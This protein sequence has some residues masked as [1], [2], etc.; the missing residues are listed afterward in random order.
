MDLDYPLSIFLL[1]LLFPGD[2]EQEVWSESGVGSCLEIGWFCT[3]SICSRGRRC[4]HAPLRLGC[5]PYVEKH[6]QPHMAL[7]SLEALSTSGAAAVG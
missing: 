2:A 5:G 7:N 1:L 6:Q 3:L 4:A